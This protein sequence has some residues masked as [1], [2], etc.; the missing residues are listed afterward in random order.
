[1]YIYVHGRGV[2]TRGARIPTAFPYL[3]SCISEWAGYIARAREVAEHE[4]Y[5][6]C[7]YRRPAEFR[8]SFWAT[9]H[10]MRAGSRRDDRPLR[11]DD[12]D[13]GFTSRAR[14][15]NFHLATF[16]FGHRTRVNS[17]GNHSLPADN[18]L[19]TFSILRFWTTNATDN[20]ETNKLRVK[21][22]VSNRCKLCL[23]Y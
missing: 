10:V 20:V 11:F 19:C 17:N 22:I 14:Y 2:Y 16:S 5:S 13:D 1:M 3:H 9:T 4:V 12:D 7:H 21:E 23:K 15:V 8:G 18:Y 6:L